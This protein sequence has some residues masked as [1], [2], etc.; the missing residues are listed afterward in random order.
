MKHVM[1]N[2][3]VSYSDWKKKKDPCKMH[4]LEHLVCSLIFSVL[5]H[6]I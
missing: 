4:G 2:M 6:L 1:K 3:A 5:K